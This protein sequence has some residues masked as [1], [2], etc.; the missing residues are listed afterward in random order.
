MYFIVTRQTSLMMKNQRV[1]ISVQKMDIIKTTKKLNARF[2]L[3]F[4]L[5]NSLMQRIEMIKTW[6]SQRNKKGFRKISRW[7]RNFFLRQSCSDLIVV[8]IWV[9]WDLKNF[10]KRIVL[11]LFLK[12]NIRWFSIHSHVNLRLGSQMNRL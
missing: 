10:Y 1:I 5:R 3:H 8:C 11:L 7:R 9:I 12:C 2:F 4:F 6:N